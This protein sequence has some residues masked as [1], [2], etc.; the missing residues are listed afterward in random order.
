[1]QRYLDAHGDAIS[2]PL[3]LKWCI[4]ASAALAYCHAQG[5]IHCDLR[6]ENML[7]DARLDLSFCDFGG[8][9]NADY[10]GEGLPDFG[11][12]DPRVESVDVTTSTEIF[13]LGSS[14]YTI[15]VGHLPHGPSILKTAKERLD[16]ADTFKRLA[17][18]GE[19]PDVSQILGGDII[20]DCW[21]H[22]ISSAEE[23]HQRL[24]RL[25]QI[26][27]QIEEN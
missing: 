11:F 14:M 18:K 9:K 15:L 27:F 23:A 22:K 2:V 20:Q 21:N 16:Y 3:R 8:S 1:M 19:F 6:P 24:I 17:L 12:F 13:G 25:F 4:Q 5:V 10:D 26:L 7:L